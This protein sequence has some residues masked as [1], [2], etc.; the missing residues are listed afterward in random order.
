MF[1]CSVFEVIESHND[2]PSSYVEGKIPEILVVNENSQ[3]I[4]VLFDFFFFFFFV[5][6]ADATLTI[7]SC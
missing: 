3:L 6:G 1:I 2:K 5:F 7:G 4:Q